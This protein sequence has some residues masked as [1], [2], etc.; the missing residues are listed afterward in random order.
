[1]V[2]PLLPVWQFLKKLNLQLLSD[3]AIALKH[4]SQRNENSGS[5]GKK[6]TI[7]K[8]YSIFIINSLKPENNTYAL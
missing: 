3:L 8:V 6:K 1:M 7:K 2:Q 4:L 5:G